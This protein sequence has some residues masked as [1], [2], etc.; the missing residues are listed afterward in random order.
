M[1]RLFDLWRRAAAPAA[2]RTPDPDL[3][4]RFLRH[5][6]EAAFAA[7]VDRHG[8]LVYGACRRLLPDPADAEDAF[9][10]TF[11]VLVRRGPQL[12]GRPLGPWLHQVAVWTA[13]NLRR[14]NAGRQ[15]L[16]RP[17]DGT[18]AVPAPVPNDVRLDV[19]AALSILPRKYRVPLVLCHLQGWTRKDAAEHLGCCESTLSSLLTRGLARLRRRFAGGEPA[20]V[21]AAA[22]SLA[23]PAALSAAAIRTAV[24]YRSSSLSA[25]ASPAVAD[26]THGVLRMF[27]VK[28]LAFAGV[29]LAAVG[30]IG[31]GFWAGSDSGPRATAQA[32][33]A[34][35]P[36][37]KV[38]RIKQ[39][40][41]DLNARL[42][43]L[44]AL[45]REALREAEREAQLE[46]ERKARLQV[47]AQKN[48]T[49]ELTVG[50][51]QPSLELKELVAGRVA[52]RVWPADLNAL[53]RQLARCQAD[54]AGPRQLVVLVE[55]S[56]PADK[57]KDVIAACH[58]AGYKPELAV[59]QHRYLGEPRQDPGGPEKKP[60][61]P[62]E[63]KPVYVIEPPDVLQIEVGLKKVGRID[64]LPRQP[65]SGTYLVRPDGSVSLGLWGTVQVAGLSLPD[66]ER[67]VQVRVL[68]GISAVE[69]PISPYELAVKVEVVTPNSKRYYVILAD[70]ENETVMGYPLTGSVCVVDALA[71]VRSADGRRPEVWVWRPGEQG[72]S[73]QTMPVDWKGIAEHGDT[74]TNYQLQPGDRVYVKLKK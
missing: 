58:A 48:G 39:E 9:Q 33:T 36:K 30:M 63:K 56:Y 61:G 13:R 29:V 7:L 24:R 45:E 53:T 69:L 8:P 4:A 70:G 59:K 51:G 73:A 1:T 66:A 74:T 60:A 27:W 31:L 72:K 47:E 10:A 16:T 34:D 5:R 67:A 25:A 68:K 11:L 35:D 21:L 23:V 44:E 20:V 43:T 52:L 32:P 57:A 15:S 55:A 26:L 62:A 12:A 46:P 64:P 28:K 2:D 50:T 22:G 6:D 17:L 38:D 37:A 19:D 65:I 3:L 14:R 41:D 71:N 18:E 40:I 49:L 42:K 54:P